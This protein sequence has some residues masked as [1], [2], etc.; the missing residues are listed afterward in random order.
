MKKG[1]LGI[2]ICT[3]VII[4]LTAPKSVYAGY[5]LGVLSKTNPSSSINIDVV[6]EN[7]FFGFFKINDGGTKIKFVIKNLSGGGST[8]EFEILDNE[9]N[10]IVGDKLQSNTTRLEFSD[11]NMPE[12]N[13]YFLDIKNPDFSDLD[14]IKL[15]VSFVCTEFSGSS[16]G[17]G[18]DPVEKPEYTWDMIGFYSKTRD[19]TGSISYYTDNSEGKGFRCY[20]NENRADGTQKF[21]NIYFW[22]DEPPTSIVAGSEISLNAKMKANILKND[23]P[24]TVFMDVRI[25]KDDPGLDFDG[26]NHSGIFGKFYSF[27]DTG[28]KSS[29]AVVNIKM[30]NSTN[31]GEQVSIY[32]RTSA[33]LYEWRYELKRNGSGNEP[34]EGIKKGDIIQFGSY[35]QDNNLSNGPENIDWIVL[36]VDGNKLLLL[37]KYAL[38]C[39]PYNTLEDLQERYPSSGPYSYDGGDNVDW[40]SVS[41]VWADSTIRTW[42]N[43][44]FYNTAFTDGEKKKICDSRLVNADNPYYEIDGGANTT[45]KVFLMSLEDIVNS[46]YGFNADP[47]YGDS[48]RIAIAT[49]YAKAM[50]VG[51][52]SNSVCSWWLRTPGS[53]PSRTSIVNS[54]GNVFYGCTVCDYGSYTGG[55][56]KGIRPVICINLNSGQSLK[57]GDVNGDGKV[58]AKDV[59]VLKRYLASGWNV[60][61]DSSVADVNG[62]GTV[63]SKDVTALRRYLLGGWGITLG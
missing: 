16:E 35:E 44:D 47:D 57:K 25:M 39:Q 50:G 38:D 49:P 40:A 2:L 11:I 12:S 13:Y 32:L 59:T 22:C 62:D 26:T 46:D 56:D 4:M 24:G 8:V 20:F 34:I 45:D 7:G 5:D 17:P 27:S 30:S 29:D 9:M 18:D 42:L 33:G 51:A 48:A 14:V 52:N 15:E 23:L 6:D 1:L 54:V 28:N 53:L 55:G 10:V 58:D 61:V 63:S 60:N 41:V 36:S 31:V 19:N 43:N 37:S 3:V 21:A